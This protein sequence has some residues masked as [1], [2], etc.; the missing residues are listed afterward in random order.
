MDKI[1]QDFVNHYTELWTT[2]KAMFGS[3]N[4]ITVN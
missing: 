3:V 2:G 1:T 4:K